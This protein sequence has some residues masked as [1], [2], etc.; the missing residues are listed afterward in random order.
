MSVRQLI[1]NGIRNVIGER[2]YTR[3]RTRLQAENSFLRKVHGVIHVGANEGQERDLYATFGLR[4]I[5][6]EPIPEVF[7]TLRRNLSDFPNQLALNYLITGEDGKEYQ[8]H[9]ANNAGASSSILDLSRHREMWPDISY[10]HTVALT[11]ATLGTAL[12]AEQVDLSHYDA[13]VLDTQGAEYTILTG[14]AS[15]LTN[16]RF[17]KVEAP[18]FEAYEGCCKIDEL[19]AFLTSHGFSEYRRLPF[20]QMPGVGTYYDATYERPPISRR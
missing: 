6:I 15:L 1:G 20:R 13:L 19:S 11:G 18:D 4:V 16:F 2:S 17:I 7:E 3:L 5:W 14:A 9:V 12:A 10:T 8:F